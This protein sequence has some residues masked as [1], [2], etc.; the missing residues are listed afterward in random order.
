MK[1]RGLVKGRE[2][3]KPIFR[4]MKD[5]TDADP[6]H[7]TDADPV[8]TTDADPVHLHCDRPAID[9]WANYPLALWLVDVEE[10]ALNRE[11]EEEEEE[12]EGGAPEKKRRSISGQSTAMILAT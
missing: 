7:T 5:T 12:A 6:V 8:H 11:E 2:A 4:I 10:R 1:D 9:M 3:V